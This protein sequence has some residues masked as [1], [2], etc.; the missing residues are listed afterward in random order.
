MLDFSDG[1][2]TEQEDFLLNGRKQR[3]KVSEN[4]GRFKG[5]DGQAT[6]AIHR[7]SYDAGK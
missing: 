4:D 1:M 5:D 3:K 7:R 2:S 6:A